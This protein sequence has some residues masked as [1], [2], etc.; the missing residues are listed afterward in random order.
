MKADEEK[1]LLKIYTDPKHPASFSG[2]SKLKQIVDREGKYNI[3]RKDI[4]AFLE[5]QDTYTTNRPVRRTFRR[6]RIITRGIK[7]QY[8]IDLIDMGRLSKYNDNVNFLIT[9]I[10]D[11]SRVAMVKGLKNKKADTVLEALKQMLSGEKKSRVVRTDF[12]GEF[13]NSKVRDYFKAN[14]IKHIYVH[15]PLKAQIVERFNKSLKQMIYRYLHNKNTYRYID[16]LS[17]IVHSYNSRP[18]RSL[19]TLSPS[20]VTKDNEI[21]LWNKL[22]VYSK[23]HTARRNTISASENDNKTKDKP[24]V[25]YRT[26][27]AAKFKLNEGDLVRVSFNRRAFERSFQQRFSEEVFRI[28][29]RLIRDNIPMYLL[30]DLKDRLIQ[31]FFYGSELQRVSQLDSKLFKIDTILKYRGKGRGREALVRFL[32]Y[33]S[34]FDEWL[35]VTSIQSI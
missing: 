33:G 18:H 31:G 2:P 21:S 15:P 27:P 5:S 13:K 34:D 19:G 12:G 4:N 17:D 10:D 22:S 9:A 26:R 11:F 7:D 29:T 32:G 14:N 3:S 24:K 23:R 28:K 6:G 25:K 20:Q 8:D 1:Y 16:K 30:A 35:P